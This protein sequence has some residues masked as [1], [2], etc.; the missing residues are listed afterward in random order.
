MMKSLSDNRIAILGAGAVGCYIGAKL[1]DA[2]FTNIDF[3]ARSGYR[4]LKDNGLEIRHRGETRV[5]KISALD[6][7]DGEYD[8]ILICVK[9]K[10]TANAAAIAANH[11]AEGGFVSSVQNGVEN[12]DVISAY[13]PKD[14]V[15]TSVIYLTAVMQQKGIL[16]YESEAKL[17]FGHLS[18][19]RSAYSD[20]YGAIL[21]KTAVNSKYSGNIK[22]RQWSKL[23]LNIMLNPL[24]AL[25]RKTFYDMSKSDEAMSLTKSLFDEARQAAF[26]NGVDIPESLYDEIAADCK[27]YKNFKSSMF[28]DIEANRNP[29]IDAILGAVV[30]S[31]EKRGMKAPYCETVLKIMTV[32]YGGWFQTPPILAADVIVI[33][34]NKVLLIERRNYPKGWAIPGG[35]A[36]LYESLEQAAIRELYEETGIKAEEK[37][38][39]LLGVYSK[40]DR[41]PRGHTVSAV[42]ICFSDKEAQA[43]DDAASAAYFDIDSLPD[44]LAFDHKA[45]LEQCK[46]KYFD[47]RIGEVE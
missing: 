31:F 15:I 2:G 20:L 9:S 34:K 44:N 42:Y 7:P 4:A 36:D 40:P 11:L 27:K 16:S 23:M 13:I 35:F 47:K 33:N 17:I 14:K 21:E 46:S 41:D 3:I 18:G 5:L 1:I 12:P 29:E 6:K 25:F 19:E 24:S 28:Q 26:F 45:I 38:L 8:I 32:K 10:D 22:A 43:G 37:D 39:E 30:R